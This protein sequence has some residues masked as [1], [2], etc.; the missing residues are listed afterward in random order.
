MDGQ[1][2][3][4]VLQGLKSPLKVP[5]YGAGEINTV[6]ALCSFIAPEREYGVCYVF[7]VNESKFR[8]FDCIKR[9]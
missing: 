1:V 7:S 8:R 5:D 6:T 3:T 9:S 4:E 2:I